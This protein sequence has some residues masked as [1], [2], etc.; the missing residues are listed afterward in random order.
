MDFIAV[1]FNYLS[2][3]GVSRLMQKVSSGMLT[4]SLG[5]IAG[6][7][8]SI[9]EFFMSGTARG[10]VL[11]G[12]MSLG[13]VIIRIL[14]PNE[15]RL[16]KS[17]SIRKILPVAAIMGIFAGLVGYYAVFH[18]IV[19][20]KTDFG[21]VIPT[22]RFSLPVFIVLST[23]YSIAL[24]PIHFVRGLAA[25]HATLGVGIL[26]STIVE[27][28]YSK[29]FI[30]AFSSSFIKGLPFAGVWLLFMY[31]SEKKDD[32]GVGSKNAL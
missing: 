22:F 21:T 1:F 11:G 26:V 3:I 17:P 8:G 5:I 23:M 6:F 31:Y 20:T 7:A 25:L 19:S 32:K 24:V 15:I 16:K 14:A 30:D 18:E 13:V 27:Y 28:W 12:F 9:F 4:V 10:P 2:K 29:D